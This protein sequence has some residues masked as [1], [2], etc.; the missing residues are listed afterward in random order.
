MKVRNLLLIFVSTAL[1]FSCTSNDE[2]ATPQQQTEDLKARIYQQ[3][4]EYGVTT[5][6]RLTDEA[7][8]RHQNDTNADI[9]NWMKTIAGIKALIGE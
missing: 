1:L 7:L 4:E 9:E 2:E 3:A 6:L 5:N 8:K